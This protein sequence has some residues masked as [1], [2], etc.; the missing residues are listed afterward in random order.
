MIRKED[1]TREKFQ[2][3]KK[4]PLEIWKF[5]DGPNLVFILIGVLAFVALL[6]FNFPTS[7]VV[8]FF[9][10]VYT[11][12]AMNQMR[13]STRTSTANVR[14]DYERIPETESYKFGL[15]NFGLGPALYLRVFAKVVEEVEGEEKVINS[16]EILGEDDPPISLREGEFL[17]VIDEEFPKLEPKYDDRT[18]NL[19]YSFVS[20]NGAETP[21]NHHK[22]RS[23]TNEQ[24]AEDA[25]E[26]RSIKLGKVREH[27]I[28]GELLVEEE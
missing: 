4:T 18:L 2:E 26:P 22:P 15:R 19:Y 16:K 23:K 6:S 7:M 3:V 9:T 20:R 24:L 27:C 5:I 21:E 28:D 17:P 1:S 13:R 12:I 11:F 10:A 25:P 8:A 14:R